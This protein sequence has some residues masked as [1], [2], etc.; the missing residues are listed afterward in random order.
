ML[1][2]WSFLRQ[3]M[4]TKFVIVT[5][6]DI[7]ARDWNDVIWAITTRMDPKRDTVMIDNTPIDYLG[8]R[9]AGIGAGVEDGPGRHAQVAGRDYTRMG[10]GHRQGRGRHPPYR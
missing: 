3:F 9:V 5:D 6:D 8:L 1:G 2:V 4:Y 7:N 10:P